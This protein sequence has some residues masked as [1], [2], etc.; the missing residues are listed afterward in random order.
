MFFSSPW[1][2]FHFFFTLLSIIVSQSDFILHNSCRKIFAVKTNGDTNPNGSNIEA[3]I[4]NIA[5]FVTSLSNIIDSNLKLS[6]TISPFM[7]SVLSLIS[8]LK[9]QTCNDLV[10]FI[11][12]IVSITFSL[13]LMNLVNLNHPAFIKSTIS[14][15]KLTASCFD[16]TNFHKSSK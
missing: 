16:V 9:V 7:L 2:F 15:I 11:S 1:H 6:L 14:L 13:L 10:L 4:F 8:L 12:R 5:L 3:T